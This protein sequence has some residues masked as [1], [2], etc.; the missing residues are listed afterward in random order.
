MSVLLIAYDLG[1]P[2]TSA[3]YEDLITKI[4]SYGS[5]RKV[6]Y[7]LWLIRTD[8]L[9]GTVRDE[10]KPYLDSND[11]LLVMR[12]TGV[13]WASRNLPSSVTDWMKENI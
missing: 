4:K 6:Q 2:E 5:Y 10:L 9:T 7:S 8:K 12:V 1:S 3:D 13:G 11:K